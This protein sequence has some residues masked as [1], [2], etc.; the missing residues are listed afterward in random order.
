MLSPFDD[1][2]IHQTAEPLLHPSS[3]DP[4]FFD[5]FF[6][7]GTI[8]ETGLFFAAALGIYPNRG[9][10]DA[11][12]SVLLEDRQLSLHASRL[13]SPERHPIAVGPISV[14]I[15][16]PMHTLRVRVGPHPG[17]LSA[18]LRFRAR[19][20]ALEEPRFTRRSGSK[21]WMNTTR[22]TQ[23][24][25]WEGS[26]GVGERRF[27]I[28]PERCWGC[29]DRSWGV[30]PIGERQVGPPASPP[31]FFWL[32]APLRFD[33]CCLLF[34]VNEDELGRPWHWNGILAPLRSDDGADPLDTSGVVTMRSVAHEL[35]WEP[36]TRRVRRARLRFERPDAAEPL[37]VSLAPARTF[38]MLGLGYLHPEWGHGIWKGELAVEEEAWRLDDC[39]PLDPRFLHVQQLCRAHMGD[40]SGWG[41]FEQLAIGPHVPSGLRGLLGP[42][43]DR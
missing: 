12:F 14:D 2:P 19:S 22:V 28:A 29:R 15:E 9:I 17:D 5:R 16:K 37:V 40:R 24:G 25:V 18:D 6:F 34:D 3:G 33:D 32:W 27:A 26:V 21:L 7:N 31:Q 41:V 35:E 11:A 36:G 42:A 20:A 4:C 30:R 13:A 10:T 23:F 38:H 8:P 1:Y 43:P 39:K